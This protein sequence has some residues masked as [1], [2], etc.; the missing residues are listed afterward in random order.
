MSK[1]AR[2]RKA[3]VSLVGAVAT[4]AMTYF[5]DDGDIQKIGG[6]V[7]AMLTVFSVYQIPNDTPLDSLPDPNQ[8]ERGHYS[9]DSGAVTLLLVVIIVILLVVFLR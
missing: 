2:Y 3:I 9:L 8:S 7:L 5:P 6:F 4:W 1:L